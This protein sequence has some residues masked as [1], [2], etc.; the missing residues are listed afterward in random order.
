MKRDQT[1][2]THFTDFHG[3]ILREKLVALEPGQS[4]TQNLTMGIHSF[5][6]DFFLFDLIRKNP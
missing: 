5:P 6:M 4:F 3:S 1:L 2:A